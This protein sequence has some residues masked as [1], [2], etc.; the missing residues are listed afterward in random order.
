MKMH[1]ASLN[2]ATGW[3]KIIAIRFACASALSDYRVAGGNSLEMCEALPANQ[4]I[5]AA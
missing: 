2:F 5:Q 1:E 3:K 4:Y